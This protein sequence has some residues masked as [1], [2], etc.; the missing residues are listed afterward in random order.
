MTSVA[1]RLLLLLLLLLVAFVLSV[2]LGAATLAPGAVVGAL[3]GTGDAVTRTIVVDLRL[4]RALLAALVGGALALSG[5]V[6]Q[7]LVRNPLAE[8]YIMG[9]SSGAAVGAVGA[10]ALGWGLLV[11]WLPTLTAF[12]GALLTIVL[13]FRVA[14]AAGR[15]MDTRV[16]LLAGVVIG[17]FFNAVILLLL[18]L[19]DIETFRSAVFWMMGSLAGARW[20]TVAVLAVYIVPTTLVLLALARGLDLLAVGEESAL[21]LG[22]PVERLKRVAFVVTSLLVAAGVAVSGVIGFIGL[23]V[24]HALRLVWGSDHRFLLPGCVLAGAAFLLLAD[25]AARTLT[26]PSELPV[27]VITAIVGVPVFVVLL[28]RRAA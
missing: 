26:S 28:T 8:P 24:P 20:R 11:P 18:T 16:L 1:P 7:A 15:A 17:A 3:L 22:V 27:G 5:A 6:F 10:A 25:T 4:P 23:V 13:V 21:Y 12:V 2:A 14:T 9:V 19:T